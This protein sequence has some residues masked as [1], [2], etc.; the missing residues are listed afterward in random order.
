[1]DRLDR[2]ELFIRIVERGSFA[3]AASEL[4]I[5]R[6][7]ATN[8][9]KALER[10]TGV[11]LLARS[12]RHLAVTPEGDAFYQRART[13]LT[14]VEETFGAFRNASPRGHLRVEAPGQLTRSFLV[15]HLPDF[16]ARFPDITISFGQSDR[17]ADLVR[18][19]VDCVIRAGHPQ[20]S[21]L[22]IRKV[23]ELPE[24]TCAS[25]AYIARHGLP[26]SLEDLGGHEMVGFVS[27]RTGEIMP[28][29]FSKAGRVET[30]LLPARVSTDNSDTAA[31]LAL[32]G[33][34]LVQAPRYRFKPYLASGALIEVLP[35]M[36]PEPLPLHALHASGRSVSHRLGV[37]LD[38]V[39]DVLAREL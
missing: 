26:H 38:W 27:S 33:L 30:R 9:V 22:Q 39:R 37:F 14:E 11:R 20:D 17:L 24:V 21:S 32:E 31:A 7:S 13:I 19:G 34:G 23:G 6:S 28:M 4:N 35:D 10:E 29:E 15:P 2:L 5:A 8:A 12:T 18:E 36:P 25:P 1:M 3:R 16:L